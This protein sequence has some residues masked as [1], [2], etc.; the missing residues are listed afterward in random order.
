MHPTYQK[1][2]DISNKYRKGK[3]LKTDIWQETHEGAIEADKYIEISQELIDLA[4]GI[5]VVKGTI[6]DLPFDDKEFDTII[7]TS[8]I[9]HTPN[10]TK[11][12][13]EYGRVGDR[14]ILAVWLTS[15]DT[16]SG[17][18]DVAGGEQFYFNREEFEAELHKRFSVL[19]QE[20]ITGFSKNEVICYVCDYMV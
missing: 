1:Y 20:K 2:I 10:Y 16:Y 13:D 7:D 8:T 5:D 4:E 18:I 17:G 14:L 15:K 6:E 19:H 11:V 9:D 3:T 12:L